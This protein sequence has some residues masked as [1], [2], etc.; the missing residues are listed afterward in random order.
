MKNRSFKKNSFV[1]QTPFFFE[2]SLALNKNIPVEV[3]MTGEVTLTGKVLKIGG[4]REK[5]LA[6]RR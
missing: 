6:A 1:G 2:I 4:L 3:A 5:V